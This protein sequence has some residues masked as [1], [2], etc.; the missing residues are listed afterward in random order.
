[1]NDQEY[2][3]LLKREYFSYCKDKSVL[4]IGPFRGDHTEIIIAENPRQIDVIEGHHRQIPYLKKRAI[5]NIILDD[6]QHYLRENKKQYDVVICFGVLYHLH[7]PLSMLEIIVN[8]CSPTHVILDCVL[9]PANIEF[10]VED[11][12]ESGNRMLRPNWKSA[13]FKLVAPFDIINQ[14]MHNMQYKLINRDLL[15]VSG[16]FNKTNFWIGAWELDEV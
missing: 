10:E 4:E 6:A 8:Q 11:D 1:M 9:D 13:G 12:N 5:D 15:D 7:D 3:N 16:E 14:S 2:T